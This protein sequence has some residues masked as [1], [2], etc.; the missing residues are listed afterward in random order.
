MV[1]VF[2]TQEFDAW[3]QLLPIINC[4]WQKSLDN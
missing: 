1:R 4:A 2:S 3:E